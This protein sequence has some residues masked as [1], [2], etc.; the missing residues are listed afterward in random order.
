VRYISGGVGQE[1]AATLRE[2][3]AAYTLWL[4]TATARGAAWLS[5]VRV[6]ITQRAGGVLMLD[7]RLDGPWL[8]A[9]LPPGDYRIEATWEDTDTGVRD[10]QL[11]EVTIAPGSA[12]RD[13]RRLTLFFATRDR[14]RERR[15]LP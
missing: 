11:T 6:R 12:G 4:A 7:H 9:D 1:E 15:A 10:V 5:D 13:P 14:T 3:R 2:N 8:M